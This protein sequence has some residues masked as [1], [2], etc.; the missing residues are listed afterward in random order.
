MA[1]LGPSC[2]A[3]YG[4]WDRL[5]VMLRQSA[6]YED[7]EFVTVCSFHVAACCMGSMGIKGIAS[8]MDPA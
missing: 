4:M 2:K 8:S 7:V 1:N 3:L 6:Q 5:S